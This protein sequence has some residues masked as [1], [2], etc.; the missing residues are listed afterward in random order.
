MHEHHNEIEGVGPFNSALA[1]DI[2]FSFFRESSISVDYSQG[3]A[4]Q[5][6]ATNISGSV[7]GIL[8]YCVQPGDTNTVEP[9]VD[10]DVVLPKG[11]S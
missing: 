7:L 2:D 11:F 6:Y 4:R 10:A 3:Q 9:W 1:M 5:H 8:G